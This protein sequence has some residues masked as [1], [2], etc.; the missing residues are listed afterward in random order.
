LGGG[1]PL[2]SEV[3]RILEREADVELTRRL[4]AGDAKAFDR[5]VEH[6]RAKIFHYSW[7]MCGHREDAEEVAQ[8]T[9]IV[10]Q[11]PDPA[12]Q[13]SVASRGQSFGPLSP[14]LLRFAEFVDKQCGTSVSLSLEI[15]QPT[16]GRQSCRRA[17]F[18][19]GLSIPPHVPPNS[20]SNFQIRKCH[21]TACVVLIRRCG[22]SDSGPKARPKAGLPAGLP[23]PRDSQDSRQY[24]GTP[25]RSSS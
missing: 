16:W 12:P 9:F 6:F 1:S 19:A 20:R 3:V 21:S 24:C 23:A 5:F 18:Q 14:H 2:Q 7:L 25:G 13:P 17:R 4:I 11:R 10:K 8:D 22:V 15:G